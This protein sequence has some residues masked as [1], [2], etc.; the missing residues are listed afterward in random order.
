MERLTAP[1]APLS[2]GHGDGGARGGHKQPAA[3]AAA[4]AAAEVACAARRA[5]AAGEAAHIAGRQACSAHI[6]KGACSAATAAAA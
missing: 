6:D 2:A 1:V 4:A 5:C 3:A